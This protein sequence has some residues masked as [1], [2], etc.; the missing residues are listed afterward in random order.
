MSRLLDMKSHDTLILVKQ[1][2][3]KRIYRQGRRAELA[4]QTANQILDAAQDLAAELWL[5]ELT[6]EHI[7]KRAGV[8]VKTVMRRFGSRDGIIQA[9]ID[10]FDEQLMQQHLPLPKPGDIRG[11]IGIMVEYL[12]Q[13]AD[14]A[15]RLI[16]QQMRYDFMDKLVKRGL[17]DHRRWI[18]AALE[19]QLARFSPG[20]REQ[21][22][23]ELVHN[24]A[25]PTWKFFRRDLGF[26]R[27]RTEEAMVA[28]VETILNGHSQTVAQPRDGRHSQ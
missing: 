1:Q 26:S 21:A 4:A 28:L 9:M 23:L 16:A 22:V 18:A 27:T 14:F 12:E 5:D 25:G 20:E 13:W 3:G 15:L 19:P 2:P 8:T 10:R 6:L 24:S 7:A 11:A 17:Q